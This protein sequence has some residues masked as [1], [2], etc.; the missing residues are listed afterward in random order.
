MENKTD[1][2]SGLLLFLLV[3]TCMGWYFAEADNEILMQEIN[4]QHHTS[5]I[6]HHEGN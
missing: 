3:F 6:R 5:P 1:Y 2:L 4:L